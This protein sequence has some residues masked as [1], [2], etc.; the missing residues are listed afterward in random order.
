MA[1]ALGYSDIQLARTTSDCCVS[2]ANTSANSAMT[3]SSSS[4][5]ASG[6]RSQ[7]D[8]A[9]LPGSSTI[10]AGAG[11]SCTDSAS[12]WAGC[13]DAAMGALLV[14]RVGALTTEAKPCGPLAVA[15]SGDTGLRH[16][17]M[18]LFAALRAALICV[19]ICLRPYCMFH[20][21]GHDKA[22]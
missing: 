17:V 11:R 9:P 21:F 14:P 16:L 8:M 19:F 6:V 3:L 2:V 1:K 18:Y 20:S 4:Q 12:A 22:M 7:L 5:F 13:R 10:G 15:T